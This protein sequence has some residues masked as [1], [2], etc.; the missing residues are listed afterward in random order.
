MPT[1]KPTVYIETTIISYL[2]AKPSRDLVVAGHQEIT[3][4]WWETV[5]PRVRGCISPFIVQEISGGDA[6]MAQK[7]VALVSGMPLL[8]VDDQVEKLGE[9]YF[10]AIQIPER[11]R[12]DALHLAVAAYH[13]VDYVLSW[14]CRHIASARVQKRLREINEQ[15]KI[16]TP[17]LCTPEGLMEV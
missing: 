5:L 12:F 3:R 4:E 8:E 11:A 2:V 6:A 15:L 16:P 1:E 9:H 13:A 14:N 17:V 10:S 7:R